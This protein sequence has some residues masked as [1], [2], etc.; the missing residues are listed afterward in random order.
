MVGYHTYMSDQDAFWVL[1]ANLGG[2]SWMGFEDRKSAAAEV[3]RRHP[4]SLIGFQ[5]FGENNWN[6]LSASLPRF[7]RITGEMIDD[8]GER[9]FVNTVAYDTCRFTP[10]HHATLW[11]TPDGSRGP[12]WDGGI[13]AATVVRFKTCDAPDV[14]EFV[15][16]NAHLDNQGKV[17]R[18]AGTQLILDYLKRNCESVPTVV[19][20]DSN[21]SVASPHDTWRD[22]D[23]RRPYHLMQEAGFTDTWTTPRPRTY[24]GFKGKD[25][26]GDPFGTYDTE[27]IFVRG[28]T[29][30]EC[31]LIEDAVG[32]VFP[33]DHYWMKALIAF[34]GPAEAAREE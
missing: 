24:H 20:A 9:I 25:Y 10:L 2:Q 17:A 12:G 11:L 27:W 22:P 4:V 34:G 21:V 29:V 6:V 5:E 16:V 19:T 18:L 30:R 33:S 1:T 8:R 3:L 28:F 23:M 15:H 7:E 26:E 31:V 14:R 13:R 32:G